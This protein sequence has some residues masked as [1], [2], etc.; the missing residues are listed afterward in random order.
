MGKDDKAG[1]SQAT[2]WD[3]TYGGDPAFFGEEPSEFGKLAADRFRKEGVRNVLE[4]GC[5]QGRDTFLFARDGFAVTALD[6][7]REGLRILE[8]KAAGMSPSSR[9]AARFVDV[10]K[11]LP[12]PDGTFD[13]CYSH[14]LLCMELA[15]D[16]IAACLREVRRVLRPGGIA[17]YSVRTTGDRHYRAGR[18]MGED[19]YE[20]G[21]FAVHFFSE[22][23]VRALAVG[24]DL[25][26]LRRMEEGSL[27]RELFGV[28][29][30]K[31]ESAAGKEAGEPAS[32]RDSGAAEDPPA[33]G[34]RFT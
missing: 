19:M 6:Y 10:R 23:K 9:V 33:R 26:D 25:V 30:R 16:E 27:P 24:Y 8:A 7:S 4:L 11:P 18:P 17:I 5:G 21:G 29:L 15:T 32:R 28:T 3:G 34:S 31:T 12:F 13:A 14:M 2:H 22:E 1:G 20:I